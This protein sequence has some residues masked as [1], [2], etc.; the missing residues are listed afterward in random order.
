MSAFGSTLSQPTSAATGKE[1][2]NDITVA[3]GPEDSVSDLAFSP[4]SELLAVASWDHKVRVY[5]ID[6]NTGLS[7]GRALFQHEA[8]V[9]SARWSVDGARICSGG[10]DKQ[11]RLFDLASQQSQ[12]IGAHDAPVRCVRAVQVGPTATEVVVSGSWDKTLKY[13]DT[14][15][16]QPVATVNLPERVYCMDTAQKLMVVGCAERHVAIID[17][18]NPQQVFKSIVSPLK[19]QTRTVACYPSGTGFAIASVEGRC[20]IQYIDDAEQ[21]K[22]GFSFRCH[23]KS[24]TGAPAN[25]T[26]TSVASETHI[27]PVNA[28]SFHP[29]YGTFSTAGSDGTFC[30]WDKDA[31]QRLKNFPNVG[32]AITATAFNR[33]GTIFAY[34]RGYD[35]SQGVG[36]NRADYPVDVKLHPS[37][38]DEIKQK[39]KR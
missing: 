17:L 12:Q 38:D 34:A 20:A 33:S 1:L 4:Q 7:Q 21:Q 9:F 18:T 8:P 19:Y 22:S 37:K 10:A 2:I 26:R 30:F 29:I 11:V 28:I 14:R 3:N 6:A 35:W 32:S 36:G 5:D 31:K 13:W 25:S 23:R 39:K 15:S 16:P 27:Y 24:P